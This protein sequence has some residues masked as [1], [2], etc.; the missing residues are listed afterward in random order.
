MCVVLLLGKSDVLA[1]CVFQPAVLL[2]IEPNSVRILRPRPLV[3]GITRHPDAVEVHKGIGS[4]MLLGATSP[5]SQEIRGL[6]GDFGIC[7][8]A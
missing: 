6:T 7:S 5:M 1:Q 8:E 3:F 4:R 2:H